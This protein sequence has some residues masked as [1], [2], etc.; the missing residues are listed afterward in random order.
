LM[1]GLSAMRKN[2]HQSA[3]LAFTQALSTA[4]DDHRSWYYRALNRMSA[5]DPQGA[6]HDLDQLIAMDPDDTHGLLRRAEVQSQL[7]ATAAARKD[8]AV[9]LT[10]QSNGPAAEEAL[11]MLGRFCMLE[12]DLRGAYGHYDNLVRIAPYNALALAERGTVLAALGR[13]QEALIDL[14][15]AIEQD[16][17]MAEAYTHLAI[18]LLRMD[19][20]QEACHALNS[21]LEMG[22]HSVE[23]ML[24]IHCDR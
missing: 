17:S 4:P 6:L 22:D 9:L 21:A 15:Q 12:G 20:K 5:G 1:A 2:H 18:V 23:Q 7:G 3:E 11:L 14:E 24:L 16:P 8:L 19:R 10:I 13:D